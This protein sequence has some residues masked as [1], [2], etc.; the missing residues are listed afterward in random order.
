M[1]KH[2]KKFDEAKSIFLLIKDDKLKNTNKS[3]LKAVIKLKINLITN[4]STMIKT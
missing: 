4:Q 3:E 1:I 2:P